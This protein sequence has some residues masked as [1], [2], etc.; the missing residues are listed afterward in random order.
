MQARAGAG[1]RREREQAEKERLEREAAEARQAANAA[2][3]ARRAFAGLRA[4]VAAQLLLTVVTPLRYGMQAADLTNAEQSPVHEN[5]ELGRGD[6]VKTKFS[7]PTG[8][9]DGRRSGRNL[10]GCR[11]TDRGSTSRTAP[12]N[13][14]GDAVIDH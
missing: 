5:N 9:H 7:A 14:G 1:S 2:E 12:M 13:S 8:I 3:A 10:R 11:G 4:P 6:G